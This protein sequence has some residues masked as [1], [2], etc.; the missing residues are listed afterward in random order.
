MA[1]ARSDQKL[2]AIITSAANPSIASS[3]FLLISLAINTPVAP[4]AV[5]PHVKQVA[6]RACKTG[7][8]F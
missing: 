6:I 2:A 3:I 8:S 5:N 4:R 7:W 1:E